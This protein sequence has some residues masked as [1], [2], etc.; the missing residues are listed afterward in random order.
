VL[1]PGSVL[2]T[3]AD[4]RRAPGVVVLVSPDDGVSSA[5]RAQ[6]S[7]QGWTVSAF[8]DARRALEATGPEV[9][10]ADAMVLDLHLADT[11]ALELLHAVRAKDPEL[12]V[13]L[14]AEPSA[15]ERAEE[16]SRGEAHELLTKP[17]TSGRHLATAV[18][19]AVERTRLL[20]G[21][22]ALE[23]QLGQ[24]ARGSPRR[25][26]SEA[27]AFELPF[28]TAKASM[29]EAFERRYVQ[30]LLEKVGGNVAE[31]ARAAGLEKSNFRRLLRRHRISAREYRQAGRASALAEVPA[32]LS[33][34]ARN[35]G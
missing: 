35:R 3:H 12:S 11:G 28:G 32:T 1:P 4:E 5:V 29:I 14:V 10:V 15:L 20:R 17:L 22:R 33:P 24:P 23:G 27:K 9:H 16:A 25:T 19:R 7:A 26:L 34:P 18:A 21:L 31:A 6:L 13:V 8:E 2:A 30:R